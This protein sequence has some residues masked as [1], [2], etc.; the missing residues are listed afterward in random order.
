M[1]QQF[2]PDDIVALAEERASARAAGDWGTADEL[3]GRIEA[4]GWRVVDE[5]VAFDL[6]PARAADVVEDGQTFYGAVE[7]VPSRLQEPASCAATVIVTGSSTTLSPDAAISALEASL[8]PG[9]Q[10]L[11]VADR[12]TDVAAGH[13][14][15]VRSAAPFGPGDA[16]QAGLRRAVGEIIVVL[17]PAR[18]P[19]G[20][21]VS[22]LVSVLADDTVAIVGTDGLL[23]DDLRRYRPAEPGDA[24]ALRSG[25]YAFRR[26]DASARRPMDARLRLPESVATWFSLELRDAG[27]DSTPRR[28]VAL[29]LP[30]RTGEAAVVPVDQARMARRDAYRVAELVR[31]RSWLA[32]S[33]PPQRRVVGDGAQDHDEQDDADQGEHAAE[34]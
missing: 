33:R 23:S 19:D 12:D 21:I 6:S 17:D 10:V 3:K 2:V 9:T 8:P 20:D 29:D 34:A 24:T 4:A 25:C 13:H 16:L 5:G 26:A 15:I 31:G 1:V 11:V 28:A 30:L 14:E 32:V 27:P 18:L 7:S 22:P